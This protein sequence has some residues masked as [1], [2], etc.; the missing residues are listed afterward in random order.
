MQLNTFS[1]YEIL[2]MQVKGNLYLIL[3]ERFRISCFTF[4]LALVTTIGHL[5]RR[6]M[7]RVPNKKVCIYEGSFKMPLP[8]FNAD[9]LQ[10]DN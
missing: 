1:A 10:N 5:C 2:L 3:N 4:L 8:S 7:N 6:K 9:Y